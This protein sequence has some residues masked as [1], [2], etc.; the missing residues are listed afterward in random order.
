VDFDHVEFMWKDDQSNV[1]NCPALYR[2][3][4]GY[5]AQ[6]KKLGEN[7][8]AKLRDLGLDE[9]GVFIPDNVIDRIRDVT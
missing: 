4:G 7:T 2:V 1:G 8:L 3:E 5:I 9:S 6:G